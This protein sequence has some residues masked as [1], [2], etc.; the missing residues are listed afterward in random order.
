M[1]IWHPEPGEILLARTPVAFATG[2]AMRV[3][4]MRWFR[5]TERHDIQTELPGWPEGPVHV[6][7]GGGNAAARNVVKGGLI[8]LGVVIMGIL[9]SQGGSVGP[10][11]SDQGSDTPDDRA[12]EVEDFPV[13]WA[14]PGTL[15]RTL[16]WQ[17]DPGRTDR[18]RY[19]TH[20]ILTDRRLVIVGLPVHKDIAIIDDEMLWEIPR[21]SIGTVEPR[22]F[23]DGTDVKITFT[24]GSWCRLWARGRPRLTRYL[25][26]PGEVIPLESLNAAQ[27]KTA[28]D[29]AAAQASDAGPPVVTRNTCGCYLITVVAPSGTRSFFG[30]SELTSVMDA[31]GTTLPYKQYHPEDFTS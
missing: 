23:K 22:D 28:Q 15:A 29:F 16:P 9:S 1:H 13:M 31:D 18:K 21:S 24:D 6:V 11:A 12:D 14:A 5:D 19:T 10:G 26:G 8:A 20:A 25:V 3:R 27:Q 2:A 30:T 7:R 4:G 17:L